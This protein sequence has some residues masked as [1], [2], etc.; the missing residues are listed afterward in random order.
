MKRFHI[1]S[2]IGVTVILVAGL[3]VMG[4][5][6]KRAAKTGADTGGERIDSLQTVYFDFDMSNIRGDQKGTVDNNATWLK[7]NTRANV[8]LEG[9]C[10]E[11]GTEEYNIALGQRRANS[12]RNYLVSSGVTAGRLSTVSY[13]EE[14][15]ACSGHD[16]S[17]WAKNRRVDFTKK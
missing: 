15:G 1:L 10:D 3:T 9:H 17:C 7:Q 16:E 6:Q 11:R 5:G 8:V 2:L 14:K 13:G 12:V 4:C